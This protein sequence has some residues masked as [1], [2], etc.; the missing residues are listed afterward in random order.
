MKAM[1]SPSTLYLL[2][3]SLKQL[4]NLELLKFDTDSKAYHASEKGLEF[5]KRYSA[6]VELLNS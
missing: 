1:A 4:L 5:L 6:L 3:K 2:R